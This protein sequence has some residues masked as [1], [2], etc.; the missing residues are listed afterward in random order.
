MTQQQDGIVTNNRSRAVLRNFYPT[1]VAPEGRRL[2][3]LQR[4]KTVAEIP[5]GLAG[6]GSSDGNG[7]VAARAFAPIC[8]TH[9]AAAL[10]RRTVGHDL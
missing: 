10:H 7:R 6:V 1:E 5:S 2:S 3:P 4:E 9:D 8:P